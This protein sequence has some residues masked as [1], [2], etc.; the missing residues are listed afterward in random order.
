MDHQVMGKPLNI[1]MTADWLMG[2]NIPATLTA[3]Q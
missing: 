3:Y 2:K 1:N